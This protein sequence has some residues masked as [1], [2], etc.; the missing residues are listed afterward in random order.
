MAK[1]VDIDDYLKV[2]ADTRICLISAYGSAG[3]GLNLFVER[4]NSFHQDFDRLVLVNTPFYSA[5]R[6]KDTGLNT[7]KNHIL[8]LKHIASGATEA[9]RLADFD[10]NLMQPKNRRI[11]N[12]EHDL[13]VLKAIIQAVG[14]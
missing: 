11:L 5:I 4:E 2:D 8:L 14:R 7:V 13:A 3:T 12:Q 9:I 6:E 1:E 10:A